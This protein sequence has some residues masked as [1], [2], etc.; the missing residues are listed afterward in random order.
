ME[1]MDFELTNSESIQY[2]HLSNQGGI[3][4]SSTF[5]RR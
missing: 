1:L 4:G 3:Y 5:R 2:N